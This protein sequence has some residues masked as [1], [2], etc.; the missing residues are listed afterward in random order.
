MTPRPQRKVTSNV[1]AKLM[2]TATP[3]LVQAEIE[4]PSHARAHE[5]CELMTCALKALSPILNL[6]TLTTMHKFYSEDFGKP[7]PNNT[8]LLLLLPLLLLTPLLLPLHKANSSIGILITS[9]YNLHIHPGQVLQCKESSNETQDYGLKFLILH[10]QTSASKR[11]FSNLG[12][13]K[14]L[15]IVLPTDI[16]TVFSFTHS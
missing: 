5:S 7:N 3:L 12:P 8:V 10:P 13:P 9:P 16:L 15:C 14:S 4:L 2:K 6:E 11:R 1:A